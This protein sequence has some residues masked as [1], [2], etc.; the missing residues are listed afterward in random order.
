MSV[1]SPASVQA[2]FAS[3]LLDEWIRHGLREVV[4]CP[5]SRST[6]LVLAIAARSELTVHVRIDERSAGFFA[7]GCALRSSVPALVVVTSGTAATELHAAVAEAS[8]AHVP[9]LIATADRPPELHDVGAAQTV[10]QRELYGPLVRAFAEPGVARDEAQRS[11]RPLAARLFRATTTTPAGPV[12][13]NVA[14]IEPLVG[15]PGPLPDAR[16]GSSPWITTV[17]AAAHGFGSFGGLRPLVIAGPG[18]TRA[19]VDDAWAHGWP[20]LGSASVA[21][22]VA[23][24]DAILRDDSAANRLAPDVVLRTG[25]L[26]A[27]KIL[28]QRLREWAAPTIYLEGGLDV[29]DPDGLITS[30][31]SADGG[32]SAMA[33]TSE[34]C[35]EYG[36]QWERASA[37]VREVAACLDAPEQQLSE[38]STARVV[39]AVGLEHG[40]P[41]VVGSSMPVRDVEW[42]TDT[43]RGV[44]FANRG[45]N[46]IDGVSSTVLGV[47][48]GSRA[49]GL[50]GD[51]TFLHDVSA[52][53]D[54]LGRA[55]GA[56][57]LVVLDNGGGGIFSFLPQAATLDEESFDRLFATPRDHDLVAIARAFGHTAELVTTVGEL[58]SAVTSALAR[59]GVEVIV[60][61]VPHHRDNVI[62]HDELNELAAH[63]VRSLS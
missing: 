58:C 7:L 52:L 59:P 5:G 62:L 29:A 8:R 57:V 43:P 41:L 3:T 17:P 63:A 4:I 45:L 25:G 38:P 56:A 18:A 20:V 61:R 31:G 50:V 19:V 53:T 6:P 27:S 42:W 54:G 55:G 12:H 60:A 21:I 44:V 15:I 14:F 1:P 30:F 23:H 46:G 39:T 48:A 47:A 22:G 16:P 28:Q 32:P 9:L 36:N 33:A 24:Y 10:R 13:L 49:L 26:P 34:L 37:A 35:A 11:W 40:V 2:T 51:V